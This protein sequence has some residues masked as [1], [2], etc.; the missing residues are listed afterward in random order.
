[1]LQWYDA[2]RCSTP[3]PVLFTFLLPQLLK[4]LDL[5]SSRCNASLLALA[6]GRASLEDCSFG[7]TETKV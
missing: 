5:F 3:M 1:M 4:W 7:K 2:V 6:R